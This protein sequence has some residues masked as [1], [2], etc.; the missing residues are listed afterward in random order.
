MWLCEAVLTR[1]PGWEDAYGV[2]MRAYA[3]QGNRR[4][5]L[6]TFERCVRN[7]REYLDVEPLARTTLI[8]E[9]LKA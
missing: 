9:E 3:R 5:A 8:Y 6:A 1:D 4:L 2:L 7:P